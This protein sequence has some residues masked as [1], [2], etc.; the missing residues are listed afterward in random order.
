MKGRKDFL[1][2][3]VDKVDEGKN[4]YDVEYLAK[5]GFMR[6]RFKREQLQVVYGAW[7]SK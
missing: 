3:R 7:C 5:G 1:S 2:G 6:A 4:E